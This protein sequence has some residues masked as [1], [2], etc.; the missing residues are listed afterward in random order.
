MAQAV[1][2]P[3]SNILPLHPMTDD[4]ALAWLRD[5]GRI[6]ASNIALAKAWGWNDVRVGRRLRAWQAKGLI[7]RHRSTVDRA[8]WNR[9]IRAS[10]S[11]RVCLAS[12]CPLSGYS[13]RARA[14][15]T[16]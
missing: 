11:A 16:G 1:D 4:Q 3:S 8:S 6:T 10:V 15:C 12:L 2:D 7:R 9:S 13:C 5:R 14:P